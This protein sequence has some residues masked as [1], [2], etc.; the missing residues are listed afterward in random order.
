MTLAEWWWLA[1]AQRARS[2]G[3]L[4]EDDA[5]DLYDMVWGSE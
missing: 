1:D 3:G 2:G 4:T 5:A